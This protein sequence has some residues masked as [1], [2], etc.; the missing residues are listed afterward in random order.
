MKE[1]DDEIYNKI[2]ELSSK[3]ENQFNKGIYTSALKY[4][5]RALDLVPAPKT[6]WDA[7]FWLYTAIGDSY[8][9]QHEF[10]KSRHAFHDAYNSADGRENPFVNLRLGQCYFE[11]DAL[12]K[13]E[14]YLM[15]AYMLEGKDIFEGEDKK[16][17]TYLKKKYDL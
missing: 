10:D 9:M 5:Y 4:Y 3:G 14:E 17:V 15:L 6:E 13:A 12:Q 11:L 2:T 16:F 1:L 8:F 7:A